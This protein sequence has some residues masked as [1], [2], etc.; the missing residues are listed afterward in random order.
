MGESGYEN[1]M[2]CAAMGAQ[3][4]NLK[5]GDWERIS[6]VG[7]GGMNDRLIGERSLRGRCGCLQV[8]NDWQTSR[9]GAVRVSDGL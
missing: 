1:G 2:A 9:I 3:M 4:R 5:V 8:A 6:E 7:E